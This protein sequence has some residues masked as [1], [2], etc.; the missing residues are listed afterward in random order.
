V[1]YINRS[2]IDAAERIRFALKA[3][4]D[5]IDETQRTC[6]HP[7]EDKRLSRAGKYTGKPF[8]LRCSALLHPRDTE[9]T[10]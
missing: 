9:P 7:P 10:L 6:P 4:S 8:C 2:L 5:L 3:V 1:G